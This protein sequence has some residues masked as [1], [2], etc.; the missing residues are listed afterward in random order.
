LER[1]EGD[2]I[3]LM[4]LGRREGKEK[5]EIKVRLPLCPNLNGFK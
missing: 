2:S 3:S 5:G 1:G 4:L